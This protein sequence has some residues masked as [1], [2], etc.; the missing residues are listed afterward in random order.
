MEKAVEKANKE[1]LADFVNEITDSNR[2]PGIII[3]KTIRTNEQFSRI[4]C[5]GKGASCCK[6]NYKE[7]ITRSS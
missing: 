4:L 2:L 6:R 5:A 3:L 1:N 7:K